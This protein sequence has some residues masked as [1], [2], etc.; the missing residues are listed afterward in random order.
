MKMKFCKSCDTE[1][2]KLWQKMK[3]LDEMTIKKHGRKFRNDYS[4]EEL[5]KKF[6]E[7]I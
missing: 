4:I 2:P 6:E 5:E 7:N 3:R 1:Y